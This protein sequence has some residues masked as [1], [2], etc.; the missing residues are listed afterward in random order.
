M[1]GPTDA[2]QVHEVVVRAKDS[3]DPIRTRL[4][5]NYVKVTQEHTGSS[6]V[7]W[8]STPPVAMDRPIY[9]NVDS[10]YSNNHS[11]WSDFYDGPNT[12][13][14]KVSDVTNGNLAWNTTT[15]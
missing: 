4:I 13:F 15:R 8:Y 11:G 1:P 2:A 6:G 12:T 7:P 10:P 14:N 5:K 3:G 9:T